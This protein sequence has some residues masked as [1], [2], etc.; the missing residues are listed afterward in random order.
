MLLGLR[1]FAPIQWVPMP[2]IDV[3]VPNIHE[4]ATGFRSIAIECRWNGCE[5]QPKQIKVNGGRSGRVLSLWRDKHLYALLFSMLSSFS[6]LLSHTL[7]VIRTRFIG[8]SSWRCMRGV[9]VRVAVQSWFGLG[10]VQFGLQRWKMI[11]NYR[12][13]QIYAYISST[14]SLLFAYNNMSINIFLL[15]QILTELS[16]YE[17]IMV[18]LCSSAC[19]LFRS[20]AQIE[21]RKKCIFE[22]IGCVAHW[23][24][25]SK[26]VD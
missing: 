9:N 25:A 3:S 17:M 16:A 24:K 14:L 20:I 23:T 22:E 13:S 12:Q 19:V 5:S 8:F 2:F 18:L 6:I 11:S 21:R 26:I 1:L 10:L 7:S 15:K 4:L